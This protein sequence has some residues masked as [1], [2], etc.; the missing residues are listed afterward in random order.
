MEKSTTWNLRN[1]FTIPPEISVSNVFCDSL[2]CRTF[3]LQLFYGEL[4]FL[5]RIVFQWLPP[6]RLVQMQAKMELFL[7]MAREQIIIPKSINF[8]VSILRCCLRTWKSTSRTIR[9][10]R[11]FW[12]RRRRSWSTLTNSSVASKWWDRASEWRK[13]ISKFRKTGWN[14]GASSRFG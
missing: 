7:I 10:W 5:T 2:L 8:Q 13:S 12:L 9:D 3:S 4:M 6:Q 1:G 14:S 11:R